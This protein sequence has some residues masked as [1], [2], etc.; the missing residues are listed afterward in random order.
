MW[1]DGSDVAVAI[2]PGGAVLDMTAFLDQKQLKLT[3]ILLTHAHLDHIEG[4]GKMVRHTKVPIYLHEGDRPFY[5]NAALQALQFGMRVDTLPPV[6]EKLEHGQQLSIGPI[7]FEVRHVPGHAPGHVI[8]Y[9]APANVAFVGDVVFNGSIGRTDLPGGN[10]TVLMRS[11]REQVLTLPDHTKLYS[12]HGPATT[13][14]QERATNP[15]LQ[16]SFGGG[17]A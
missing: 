10:Y 2:D 8:L 14:A 12:G 4:V 9:H 13:V 16:P 11:I 5:D 6:D 17:L 7:S 15:F 1:A 3:A